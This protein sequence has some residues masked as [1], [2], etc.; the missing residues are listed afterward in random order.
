MNGSH[1]KITEFIEHFK[2]RSTSVYVAFLDASKAF[3][4]INR[5]ILSK[6]LIAR[7]A[8]IYL[9]KCCAFGIKISQCISNVVLSPS[10]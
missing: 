5:Y 3:G 2:R 1:K 9:V 8:L 10:V 4:K 6:K 7:R